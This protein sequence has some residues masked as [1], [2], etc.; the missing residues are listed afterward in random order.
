MVGRSRSKQRIVIGKYGKCELEVMRER[1]GSSLTHSSGFSVMGLGIKPLYSICLASALRSLCHFFVFCSG[2]TYKGLQ[3]LNPHFINSYYFEMN[4]RE[5]RDS[6]LKKIT[7]C[8]GTLCVMRQHL[9]CISSDIHTRTEVRP[10]RYEKNVGGSII[11]HSV[12]LSNLVCLWETEK[13]KW[14][15]RRKEDSGDLCDIIPG[16]HEHITHSIQGTNG[17]PK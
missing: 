13:K 17:R 7:E 4:E 6:W 8:M 5:P 16:R 2:I 1:T 10:W 14:R 9:H 12:I 3:M 15:N 11:S